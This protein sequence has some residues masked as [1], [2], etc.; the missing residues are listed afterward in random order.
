M[1]NG[2]A[3]HSSVKMRFEL[4][5][6]PLP[7]CQR[8]ERARGYH[9]MSLTILPEDE[10]EARADGPRFQLFVDLPEWLERLIDRLSRRLLGGA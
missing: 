7:R 6:R 2:D 3:H 10:T 8:L 9:K 1:L 5:I 4:R